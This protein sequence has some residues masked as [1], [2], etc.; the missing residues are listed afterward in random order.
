MNNNFFRSEKRGAY[1]LQGFIFSPLR[2]N[3]PMQFLT[4]DNF[5]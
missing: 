4:S 1:Y 2:N 5:K 3:F